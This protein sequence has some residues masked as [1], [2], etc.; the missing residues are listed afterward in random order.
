MTAAFACSLVAASAVQ[1]ASVVPA[2]PNLSSASYLVIDA[3]TGKVIAERNSR[4]S[5]PP[6]SLTK[7]MTGY[8]AAGEIEGGR[9]ALNDKVSVSVNAW[10]TPGSRMFIQEGTEV[11]VEDLL[12]GII[13]QSGNDASVAL[14]EHIA[15]SEAAFADMMNR[16][17]AELGMVNSNFRNAT[18]LPAEDHYTTAWDLAALTRAYIQQFPENYA[19]NSERS[20]TYN[21]IEQPNRNRLLWRDRTVDGVKTGY[22][23]AAGYCLLAS[24]EREGMRLISVVMGAD[25]DAHRVQESQ[26]LLSYGFR[27]FETKRLYE[28]DAP[29]ESAEVWYGQADAVELGVAAPVTI[30]FP[31]G[32]YDQVA[33]EMTL[34]EV[35]EAPIRAG[36]ALGELRVSVN[37]ETL[38]SGP[39]I[40]L[41][42][43][44]EAGIFA[45]L[46]DYLTLLFRRIFG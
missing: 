19:L 45:Q 4:E 33:V 6:A 11:S 15:G 43:V 23:K 9:I 25:N 5:M 36:D 24:A 46:G 27:F 8:V 18:G 7:V 20:F 40:A 3:D 41:S 34:P 29:L 12:R 2:P 21:D 28:A 39:L 31:R 14:A 1:G 17:A 38:H 42:D 35:I 22:T 30:T 13:I 44:A 16:Q 32:H 26:M 37:E 10:R